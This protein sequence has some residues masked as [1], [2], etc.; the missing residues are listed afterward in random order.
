MPPNEPDL[1]LRPYKMAVLATL[2]LTAILV[3]CVAQV[4]NWI[5]IHDRDAGRL[6]NASAWA[7]HFMD[8]T[9]DAQSLI[10]GQP[11]TPMQQHGIEMVESI[12][13]VFGFALFNPSGTLGFTSPNLEWSP[14]DAESE[15]ARRVARSGE[16]RI[17]LAGEIEH[18]NRTDRMLRIFAPLVGPTGETL[19]VMAFSK[20][21]VIPTASGL[22]STDMFSLALPVV[23]ALIF[24]CPML[25]L[26]KVA[27]R[28]QAKDHALK[29]MSRHDPLTGALNR[30]GLSSVIDRFFA[31]RRDPGEQVGVLFIDVDNFK[32]V[33]DSFG[34][35]AGDA[36]LQQRIATLHEV[37]GKSG[38]VG[39]LGGDE[40][41]VVIPHTTRETLRHFANVILRK[42]NQ[43]FTFDG[44]TLSATFS[45]G[46][47]L[48]P[49]GQNQ[50]GAFANAD[51]ALYQ[52]KENGRNQIV[53]YVPS[54]DIANSR[55]K[56]VEEVL[57]HAEKNGLLEVHF[58]P[59]VERSSGVIVGFEALLRLKDLSGEPITPDEFIP[60]AER[61]GL[62]HSIGL[63]TLRNAMRA[64]MEWDDDIYVSV[65]LS[66]VQFQS[67]S[68]ADDIL[69]AVQDVGLP[70]HRLELELTESMLLSDEQSVSG[71][72]QTLQ[73][74]G[75]RVAMDDFG[76]GYS[77]LGYL[78]KYHFDKLKIDRSFLQGHEFDQDRYRDI[79]ETIV[80]L[81]H[82]LG[83]KV[84]AEGVET[85]AQTDLLSEMLCDQFQGYFFA[86]PM[87]AAQA[88]ELA[89]QVG[90]I[91]TTVARQ[92][93]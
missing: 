65:N 12:D 83:M 45:I 84:T 70:H 17:V 88:Q 69:A 7:V 24:L 77:S 74:H 33:N 6:E 49:L 34:H 87:T 78:W 44:S 61:T 20:A 68:L 50:Q 80:L 60:I 91:S 29:R 59:V 52:A 73:S 89:N 63:W 62:I 14:S 58:Q 22:R 3:V 11:P 40:F 39:R 8:H 36:L 57:R 92:A 9:P 37:I 35:A 46:L 56:H 25:Y 71:T 85:Q 26:I 42:G 4:L 47:H 23:S 79:I 86:R 90:G 41:V 76:T 21:E 1:S 53:E 2:V 51:L 48:S 38:Y 43:P 10:S 15:I 19:G 27:R 72:I 82:K 64:A 66:P 55:S 31:E 5:R 13:P 30:T 93:G 54:L 67:D 75:V 16:G 32:T 18:H 81:G 28:E